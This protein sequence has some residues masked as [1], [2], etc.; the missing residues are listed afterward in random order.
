MR[1]FFSLIFILLSVSI[2]FAQIGINTTNPVGVFHVDSAGDTDSA[3]SV[4]TSD[5]VEVDKYG[6]MG[7][8]VMNPQTKLDIRSTTPGAIRIADTSEGAGKVLVSDSN[9]VGTWKNLEGNTTWY[10]SLMGGDAVTVYDNSQGTDYLIPIT[11]TK[12]DISNATLGSINVADGYITVP[13]TG[14]YRFMITATAV[15]DDPAYTGFFLLG[16]YQVLKNGVNDWN[17]SLIGNT[18]IPLTSYVCYYKMV[19]LN[20]GDKLEVKQWINANSSNNTSNLSFS[21]EFIK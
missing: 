21:V 6:N 18:N 15:L 4:N 1:N 10:A 19:I 9:G 20:A 2:S 5:D 16:S 12:S 7:I 8:G 17:P 11:F 14:V 13:F 3:A